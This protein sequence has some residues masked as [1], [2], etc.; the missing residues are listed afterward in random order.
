[1]T[2]LF[3]IQCAFNVRLESVI[4]Q[5]I[6]FL[7]YNVGFVRSQPFRSN[8]C[9]IPFEMLYPRDSDRTRISRAVISQPDGLV[10][11]TFPTKRL[12]PAFVSFCGQFQLRTLEHGTI[13]RWPAT[14]SH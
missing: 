2:P 1:M 12:P 4:Y 14:T 13:R 7:S 9:S 6:S 3:L 11:I 10:S 8:F 5:S